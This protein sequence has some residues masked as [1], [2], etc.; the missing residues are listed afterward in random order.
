MN[1]PIIYDYDAG[2]TCIDTMYLYAGHAACYLMTHKGRAA[3]IDTGTGN[4]VPYLLEVLKNKNLSVDKVDYVIPTHVHLDHAGGAGL[5]MSKLPN[6][7]L[8]IHPRGSQHMI[9]PQKLIAGATDVYG[10]EKFK[11]NFGDIVP[12][13]ESRVI[14]AEDFDEH[15]LAGRKLVFVDTPGHARH[16]F[17]IYD[18]MSEGFFTGDTFGLSYR[19]LDDIDGAFILPTTTPVQFDPDAWQDSLT[20]MLNYSPKNMYLTHFGRITEIDRLA[21]DLRKDIQHYS[22]VAK[23]FA[24]ATGRE[25]KI[26][27]A[28]KE[29][30]HKRLSER[31]T[32]TDSDVEKV[33]QFLK[34]DLELNT[35]GL[36]I[37]LKRLEK[38]AQSLQQMSN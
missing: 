9:D 23:S 38:A 6:A 34:P 7:K 14:V 15:T 33:V 31:K 1:E 3:F 26:L 16:H 5:L 11:I 35:A 29:Y 32:D 28:L 2:I 19:E 17:C 13:D 24:T 8:I 30:L 18:E 12:I 20:K 37:W 25:E 21:N 27:N 36:E 22:S 4:T 10:Q